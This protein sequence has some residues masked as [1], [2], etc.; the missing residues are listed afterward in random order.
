MSSI[1][2]ITDGAE[3]PIENSVENDFYKKKE[4]LSKEERD[5]ILANLKLGM[6]YKHYDIQ[7]FKTVPPKLIYKK[8]PSKTNVSAPSTS[9]EEP[10]KSQN[11]KFTDHHMMKHFIKLQTRVAELETKSKERNIKRKNEIRD[12][13]ENTHHINVDDHDPEPIPEPEPKQIENN[14]ETKIEEQPIIPVK[15]RLGWRYK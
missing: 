3:A 13:R 6:K 7:F 9:S 12:L 8:Q 15:K 2:E 4:D 10:I 14:V 11:K 5:E 1:I